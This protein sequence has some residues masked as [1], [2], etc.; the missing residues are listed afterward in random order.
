MSS[1]KEQ[2]IAAKQVRRGIV[3]IKGVGN[4]NKRERPVYIWNL[5]KTSKDR[6]WGRYRT[7]DEAE[8]ALN[9]ALRKYSFYQAENFE[10][11]DR[12]NK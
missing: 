9:Q 3:D 11:E 6:I 4:K 5:R 8:A 12:S 1:Y 7:Y 10:I 2:G